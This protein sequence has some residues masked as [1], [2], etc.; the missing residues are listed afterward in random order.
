M[1]ALN[2]LASAVALTAAVL[3]AN[4][5]SAQLARATDTELAKRMLHRRAVEAAIW[6]MPAVNDRLMHQAMDRDT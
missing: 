1:N 5:G 3:T 4:P 2:I 6:S